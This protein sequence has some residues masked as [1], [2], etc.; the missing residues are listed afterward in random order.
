MNLFL[1]YLIIGFLASNP[2]D[3]KKVKQTIYGTITTSGSYCGGVAPSN[4][5][6][7]EAQAKRPMLFKYHIDYDQYT[8]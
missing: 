1:T 3:E 7:Q 4:E 5:M 2:T 6:L 8:L